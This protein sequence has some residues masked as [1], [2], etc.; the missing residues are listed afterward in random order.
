M[1]P[2]PAPAAAAALAVV[3]ALAGCDSDGAVELTYRP[4]PATELRYQT[5]VETTTS[6]ELSCEPP[7]TETERTTLDTTHRVLERGD[8]GVRVEVTLS[9]PGVGT[10][11][12]V[13]RFDRA[14]Q[15]TAVEEV[16]G[17]PAAALGDLGL[18]EV[19]PPAAG[20]PPDRPLAPGD[21]WEIDEEV[22]LDADGATERLRGRGRLVA[23]GVEDGR[24]TARIESTTVLPVSTSTASPQGTRTL[25]GEQVTEVE[26]T[27]DVADGSLLRSTSVTTG[28]YDVVLGPPPGGGGDP[29]HGMLAVEVRSELS[30]R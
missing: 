14:A 1:R 26:A 12:I 27:Y 25:D 2:L 9:R 5:E 6:T 11:T 17:I 8:D 4:E 30:R 13:V 29:C 7:T 21:R 24:D 23:L 28:S 3:A 16:E 22:T 10:R 19:F 20:A 15:L 18:S